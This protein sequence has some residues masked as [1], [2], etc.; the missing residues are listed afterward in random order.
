MSTNFLNDENRR[1]LNI[2]IANQRLLIDILKE[3]E[4]IEKNTRK[5]KK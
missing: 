2:L 4:K 5:K 3:L 1:I